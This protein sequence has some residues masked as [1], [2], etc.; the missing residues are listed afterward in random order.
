MVTMD[1][2]GLRDWPPSGRNT[3]PRH[4]RMHMIYLAA[5][6]KA[7]VKRGWIFTAET[8]AQRDRWRCFV[9]GETVLQRWSA[10]EVDRAPALTFATAWSEGGAY[11]KRNARLAHFG[12]AAFPDAAF[13]RRLGQLLMRDLSVKTHASRDDETCTRGHELAGANL[14]KSSDGR[15]R[16]RQCRRDRESG[17]RDAGALALAD[18]VS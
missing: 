6:R 15:R 7:G 17:G 1:D 11:D 3:S 16:C 2:F 4:V 14:L 5:A 12:C 18:G 10:A 13:G 9:C 8:I